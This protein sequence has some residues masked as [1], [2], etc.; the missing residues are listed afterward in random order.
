MFI[1]RDL[2]SRFSDRELAAVNEW[3][4]SDKDVHTMR[5]HPD[6]GTQMLG[7]AWGSKL[8]RDEVRNLWEDSW[9]KGFQDALVW[10]K[11]N[12]Y[13]PDQAFLTR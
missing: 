11:R 2:D 8:V 12:D 5:D 9:Y 1:S 4:K 13:G 3:L 6:H 7:S 10:A